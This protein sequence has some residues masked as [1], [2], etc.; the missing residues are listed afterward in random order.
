MKHYKRRVLYGILTWFK[1]LP[2][3]TFTGPRQ[4]HRVLLVL[5]VAVLQHHSQRLAAS[6]YVEVRQRDVAWLTS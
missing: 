1:A 4:I 3:G 2:L 5:D 6:P